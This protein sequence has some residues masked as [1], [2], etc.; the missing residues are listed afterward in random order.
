M[1]PAAS[2]VLVNQDSAREQVLS[3]Q[4]GLLY[5]NA[6]LG[7]GVNILAASVLGGLQWGII[8]RPVVIGWWLYMTA[9][10]VV[11]YVFARRWHALPTRM[12]V[13]GGARLSRLVWG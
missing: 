12:G 1:R 2:G 8:S 13:V 11:R 3:A 7:V 9:T 10:S 5:A 6:N 4:L